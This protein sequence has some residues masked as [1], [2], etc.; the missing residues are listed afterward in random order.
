M[1]KKSKEGSFLWFPSS[2]GVHLLFVGILMTSI[3]CFH[4]LHSNVR[5]LGC[6]TWG[7]V[8]TY[9]YVIWKFGSLLIRC[10]HGMVLSR[11]FSRR[12]IFPSP[13][14]PASA[15]LGYIKPCLPPQKNSREGLGCGGVG[16]EQSHSWSTQH[17]HLKGLPPLLFR[18]TGATQGHPDY[19]CCLKRWPSLYSWR[20]CTKGCCI[21]FEWQH[22]G[23][24]QFS[25]LD[26]LN[27]FVM[28]LC[29][30]VCARA[31]LVHQRLW[32]LHMSWGQLEQ[33]K[34]WL[35][36]LSG[37]LKF[38]MFWLFFIFSFFIQWSSLIKKLFIQTSPKPD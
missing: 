3:G 37:I 5:T 6:V 21:S 35:T 17:V 15:A 28:C 27:V 34:I 25:S 8:L 22:Y 20:R 18:S 33:M 26:R 10:K 2:G 38:Q 29:L 7:G 9:K 11:T 14:C 36:R 12:F 13:S 31:V 19:Y 16:L 4:N 32:S 1:W 30:C 24:P 23:C